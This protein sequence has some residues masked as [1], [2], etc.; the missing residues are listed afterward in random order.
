MGRDWFV[1][2]S[3]LRR[4]NKFYHASC[5]GE[6]L[7]LA[8]SRTQDTFDAMKLSPR[9]YHLVVSR[10]LLRK[11]QSVNLKNEETNLLPSCS[12]STPAN[13]P[14]GPQTFLG[15]CGL[16]SPFI[17][18]ERH[19]LCLAHMYSFSRE[20]NPLSQANIIPVAHFLQASGTRTPNVIVLHHLRI[21]LRRL[22]ILIWTASLS[23]GAFH[24]PFT[25][26]RVQDNLG[27]R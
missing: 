13:G 27:S 14:P 26:V 18:C 1:A 17:L 5:S 16:C 10:A 12:E 7:T 6:D 8:P 4:P 24:C 2:N 11:L 23:Q 21:R 20:H 22:K 25:A 3:A 19:L 15:S 9:L